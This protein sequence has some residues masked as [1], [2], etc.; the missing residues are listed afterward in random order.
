M[1]TQRRIIFGISVLSL[2]FGSICQAESNQQISAANDS[3]SAQIQQL[4]TQLTQANNRIAALEVSKNSN[5]PLGSTL[6][7]SRGRSMNHP[8]GR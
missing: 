6:E 3:T 5:L 8:H 4:Q 1:F 7:P 2:F